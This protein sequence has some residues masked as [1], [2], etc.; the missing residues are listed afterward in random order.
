MSEAILRRGILRQLVLLPM[1]GGGVALLGAPTAVAEPVTTGLLDAYHTFLRGE[2][3]LLEQERPR[4]LYE[5]YEP[6]PKVAMDDPIYLSWAEEVIAAHE[7]RMRECNARR[8][9]TMAM[10]VFRAQASSRAALVL[11]A[12]GVD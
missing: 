7:E 2:L 9:R 10:P 6:C 1:L 3:N 4:E 11:S 5:L 12:V 8:L